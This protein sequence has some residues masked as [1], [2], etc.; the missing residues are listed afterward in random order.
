MLRA[1]D[2]P[3]WSNLAVLLERL[4]M[5]KFRSTSAE[6]VNQLGRGGFEFLGSEAKGAVP[7]LVEIYERNVSASSRNETALTLAEFGEDAE[8]AVPALIRGLSDKNPA[9]FEVTVQALRRMN[10]KPQLM[11]PALV[12]CLDDTNGWKLTIT[13]RA[14]AEFGHPRLALQALIRALSDKEPGDFARTAEAVRHLRPKP[15]VVMA[16]V[17]K[18]LEDANG[19]DRTAAV[20]V[21]YESSGDT[22]LTAPALVPLL[23]DP[24]DSVEDLAARMLWR[25]DPDTATKAGVGF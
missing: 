17:A 12:R 11:L 15:P 5:V 14:L 24:D 21:I 6:T 3:L 19:W 25:I 1:K 22:H 16:A 9:T 8:G 18:C 7:Q 13:A 10:C 2:S 23:D 20:W 4:P